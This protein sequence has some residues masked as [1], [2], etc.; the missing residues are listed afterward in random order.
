MYWNRSSVYVILSL[1][2]LW[3][4]MLQAQVNQQP[5][6]LRFDPVT[7]LPI[8]AAPIAPAQP[9]FDPATGL[10]LVK[11]PDTTAI[12]QFDPETG[13]PVK[14]EPE[15]PAQP[16]FDPET[17]KIIPPPTPLKGRLAAGEVGMEATPENVI[18]AAEAEAVRSH[19][20]AKHA[21]IGAAGCL[22]SGLGLAVTGAYVESD[23]SLGFDKNS[24]SSAAAYYRGLSPEL[25]LV[26]EQAYKNKVRSLRRKSVYGTQ[27]YCFFGA[28][29]FLSMVFGL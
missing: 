11:M 6:S 22:F 7:G 3:S 8:K 10:P 9:Q 29:I 28:V 27:L 5:D 14:A 13:L 19:N 23:K 2:W 12:P 15:A 16:Q 1:A 25:Q 24:A 17:G 26:Y 21:I 18:A 4:T 20:K